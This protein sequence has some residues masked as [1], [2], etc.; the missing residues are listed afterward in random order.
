MIGVEKRW[1]KHYT[2]NISGIS[3]SV[4]ALSPASK[5]LGNQAKEKVFT[6]VVQ[7]VQCHLN[8]G[9]KNMKIATIFIIFTFLILTGC[10]PE[11]SAEKEVKEILPEK[12]GYLS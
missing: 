7:V 2:P 4:F 11:E 1:K 3:N 9:I 10:K 8:H 6:D 5:A 12:E